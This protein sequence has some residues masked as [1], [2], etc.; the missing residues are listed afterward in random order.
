MRRGNA[1]SSASAQS[2]RGP[3]QRQLRVG[4]E[5][6]HALAWTL[7]EGNIRDPA[8][9]E[10]P[11]TVTEVRVSPDLRNATVFCMPL[12]G[13]E[14][15]EAEVLAGLRRVKPYLRHE[16]AARVRMRYI[17]DLTF[18]TDTSFDVADRIEAILHSP[19]VARDVDPDESEPDESEP[20]ESEPGGSGPDDPES[21]GETDPNRGGEGGPGHGA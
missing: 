14:A 13:G 7:E 12:G 20:D 2:G 10:T 17:P 6:R 1:R 21:E 9:A 11:V 19:E 4:E 16:L 18:A 8:L 5:L 3:G 15:A